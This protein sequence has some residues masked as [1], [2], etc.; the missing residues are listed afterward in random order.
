MKKEKD[1]GGGGYEWVVDRGTSSSP[2]SASL[3]SPT[4]DNIFASADGVVGWRLVCLDYVP[5]PLHVWF[6]CG[7]EQGVVCVSV[8]FNK[9][10]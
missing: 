10:L 7:P 2:L 1:G 4:V 3:L 6:W 9:S 5:V 8:C